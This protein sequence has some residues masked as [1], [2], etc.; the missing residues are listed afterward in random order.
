MD[1]DSGSSMDKQPDLLDDAIIHDKSNVLIIGPTG[2]GKGRG[3]LTG[4]WKIDMLTLLCIYISHD[5]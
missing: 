2:T 3:D 4:L 1:I 5:A